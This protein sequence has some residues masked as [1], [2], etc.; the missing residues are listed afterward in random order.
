VSLPKLLVV[1]DGSGF[2]GFSRVIRG[3]LVPLAAYY[4]IH[5]LAVGYFGDPHDY[6][7]PLYPAV[8]GGDD[9]GVKRIRNLTE[10]IRPDLIFLVSTFE[11]VGNY[12]E[13]L[14]S[15]RGGARVVAYCPVESGPLDP[16]VVARLAGLHRLVL[17]TQHARQLFLDAVAKSALPPADAATLSA[18]CVMPH[19]VD[20]LRF[21]PLS[22]AAEPAADKLEAK[23]QLFGDETLWDSFIVLNANRNQPRKRID[24]T[25]EGFAIFAADKPG[26]VRLYLHMGIQDVGW[27]VVTLAERYGITSRLI[28]SKSSASSPA[29]SDAELNAIYN[30]CD[31][32]LNTSSSEGW[33]LTSFEHGATRAAQLM[34]R[35]PALEEL[36]AGQAEM[37][38]PALCV[39]EPGSLNDSYLI[40]AE[41]VSRKLERLYRDPAHRD[42]LAE[43]ALMNARRPEYRWEN[44]AERWRALFAGMLDA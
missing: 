28:L 20:T 1:G 40:A 6:P 35:Q 29:V 25:I 2:T 14:R 17:Y 8:L 26:N 44:I 12:L 16:G 38:E 31:V 23:R 4:R 24:A 10:V 5:H 34:T 19:G 39:T 9:F 42:S 3:I 15:I 27:N 7:W 33:G 21:H 11:T 22:G 36:W 13:E 30:A 18:P 32:G 41:E 43:R 37:L